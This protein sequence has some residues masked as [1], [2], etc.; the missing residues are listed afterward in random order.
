MM[1]F[2]DSYTKQGGANTFTKGIWK[3]VYIASVSSAAITSVTAHT[4][5]KGEYPT[6]PLGAKQS[7]HTP[8]PHHSLIFR[9]ASERLLVITAVASPSPPPS[10]CGPT[11]L[12]P[13][14]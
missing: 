10:T 3:S 2:A 1:N 14:P 12:P 13:A 9:D 8:S 6:E 4:F 7:V 5:Y 11:R